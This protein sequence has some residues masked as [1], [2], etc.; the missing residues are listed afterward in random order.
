MVI[1]HMEFDETSLLCSLN[2]DRGKRRARGTWQTMV[3]ILKMIVVWDTGENL[4]LPL[5]MPP[6]TLLSWEAAHQYYALMSHPS[7]Q[8]VNGLIKVLQRHAQESLDVFEADGAFSNQHLYSLAREEERLI[9][10]QFLC[11][12][13]SYYR[14][15][16]VLGCT[17]AEPSSAKRIPNGKG[18]KGGSFRKSVIVRHVP[19]PLNIGSQ[20]MVLARLYDCRLPL[21]HPPA[22]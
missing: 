16:I 19:A 20:Q 22:L 5:V 17:S 2:P 1:K 18:Q 4:V 13:L 8:C 14:G 15:S 9:R 11:Y 12:L 3:Y 6:V 21:H 7:F 10:Q